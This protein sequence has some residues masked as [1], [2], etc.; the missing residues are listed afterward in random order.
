MREGPRSQGNVVNLLRTRSP[1]S[2]GERVRRINSSD[3]LSNDTKKPAGVSQ[4]GRAAL[5]RALFVYGISKPEFYANASHVLG[6]E[7]GT[8]RSRIHPSSLC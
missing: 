5:E 1:I 3:S 7:S 2:G 4:C 6:A 8:Q